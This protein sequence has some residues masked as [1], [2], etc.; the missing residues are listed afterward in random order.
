MRRR[1][2]RDRGKHRDKDTERKTETEGETE[3]WQDGKG[4]R[5]RLCMKL[6]SM[7]LGPSGSCVTGRLTS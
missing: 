3:T 1:D 2:K 4:V 5:G 6:C 7:I